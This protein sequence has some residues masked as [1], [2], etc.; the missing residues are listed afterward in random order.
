MECRD[1]VVRIAG[2]D[3]GSYHL[4]AS[5]YDHNARTDTTRLVA[6]GDQ[7]VV[8]HDRYPD[9][10][11][12]GTRGKR[13]ELM[14]EY[15]YQFLRFW[16]PDIVVCED[17]YLSK[18]AAPYR[19]LVEG[20][21]AIRQALHRYDPTMEL[22]LVEPSKA[23]VAFGAA[24]KGA[25]KDGA[26]KGVYEWVGPLT[27]IDLTALNEHTIDAV[28]I[29]YWGVEEW[30]RQMQLPVVS[31]QTPEWW[32]AQPVQKRQPPPPPKS[33]PRKRTSR[34]RKRGTPS[35]DS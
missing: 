35:G 8:D 18:F 6:V 21:A 16:Q 27:D 4:G 3:P 31:K 24:G 2:I 28:G 29:G 25:G 22:L 11:V 32:T 9:Y 34:G 10:D 14:A 20:I 30:R 7:D 13:L 15:I 1:D 12:F 17:A 23:K 26:R 19:S 33:P 5:L